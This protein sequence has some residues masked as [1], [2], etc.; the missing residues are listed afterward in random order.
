MGQLGIASVFA[1][2]Y[3]ILM[4]TIFFSATLIILGN[5]LADVAYQYADPRIR[6]R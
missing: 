5:L 3:P 4:G 6:R 2:D 1:R